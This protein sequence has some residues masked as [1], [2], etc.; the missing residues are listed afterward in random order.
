VQRAGTKPVNPVT[1]V[2]A[3]DQPIYMAGIVHVAERCGVRILACCADGHAALAAIVEHRPHVAVLDQRMP[4]LEGRE[5]LAEV[6]RSELQTR[7]LICSAHAEP[8]IV[9]ALIAGGARGFVEK[10]A[11]PAELFAAVR[12][13]AA[14][15]VY[16][17]AKLQAH[18]NDQVAR[19]ERA[20]SPRELEVVRYAAEGL[21]D[22]EIALLMHISPETVRTNLK[23]AQEKLGVR[24]RTALSVTAVRRGLIE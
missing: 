12:R 13:V 10:V 14:G 16:L 17:S 22:H 3:D 23:R 19:G 5:V 7:V 6:K 8:A 9:H 2:V 4:G 18:F 21:K 20:L 24:G 1:I 11:R 15:G